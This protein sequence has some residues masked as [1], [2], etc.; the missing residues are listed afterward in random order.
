MHVPSRPQLPEKL[1]EPPELMVLRRT[2]MT[3]D[4]LRLMLALSCE[5]GL[6]GGLHGSS[7]GRG[8]QC[9]PGAGFGNPIL[10][11]LCLS[12]MF[13]LQS[14]CP[15][16]KYKCCTD[17]VSLLQA[18]ASL[19]AAL[20]CRPT[21]ACCRWTCGSHG[22]GWWPG[23]AAPPQWWGHPAWRRRCTGSAHDITWQSGQSA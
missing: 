8:Q 20:T 3:C 19:V 21:G 10:P 9:G 7:G 11:I 13:I 16:P 17:W 12:F 15:D 6:M 5:L 2:D 22:P 14:N 23:H 1:P 18:A 4:L